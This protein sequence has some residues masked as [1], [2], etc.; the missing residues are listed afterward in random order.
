[1]ADQIKMREIAK[2]G[3]SGI[4]KPT[5][6]VITNNETWGEV[7]T[8]HAVRKAAGQELPR[9]DFERETVLFVTLGRKNTGGYSITIEEVVTREEEILVRVKTTSPAPGGFTLQALTSPFHIVAIESRNK[10]IRF[11]VDGKA[12]GKTGEN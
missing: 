2:G 12:H 6:Q 1:M 11:T 9:V 10:P 8:Q 5:C 3:M 7:W 4:T